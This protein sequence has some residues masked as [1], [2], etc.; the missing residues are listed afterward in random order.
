MEGI[1]GI[2]TEQSEEGDVES[3]RRNC[4][5]VK[6]G[7]VRYSLPC[8][9]QGQ[10]DQD[11]VCV[12]AAADLLHSMTWSGLFSPFSDILSLDFPSRA[13]S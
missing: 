2:R 6:Q 12:C 13:R 5:R 7:G 11:P 10:K 3:K 8:C 4:R 1:V 9:S